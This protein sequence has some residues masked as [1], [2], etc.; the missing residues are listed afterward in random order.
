MADM[1]TYVSSKQEGRRANHLKKLQN[2]Y[3]LE[4]GQAQCATVSLTAGIFGRNFGSYNDE[5]ISEIFPSNG[6]SA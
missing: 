3:P 6:L 2:L 1:L 4:A 5:T